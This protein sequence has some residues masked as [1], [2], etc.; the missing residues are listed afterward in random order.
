MVFF[1]K[2]GVFREGDFECAISGHGKAKY[3]K[4]RLTKNINVT[5]PCHFGRIFRVGRQFHTEN[6]K[7]HTSSKS[8]LETGLAMDPKSEKLKTN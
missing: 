5:Q 3:C 7:N 8:A 4:F 1:S 2:R 6:S